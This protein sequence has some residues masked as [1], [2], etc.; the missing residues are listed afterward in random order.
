MNDSDEQTL[1][2]ARIGLVGL[3]GYSA[4]VLKLLREA[5]ASEDGLT[6]LTDVFVP[7][8]QNH[9]ATLAEL[10]DA[11]C[12]VHESFDALLA[13]EAEA[14]WLPVPIHLHRPMTEA[15]LAA[16]KTV[17]LEKPVAG[18]ID[19][20]DALMRAEA[21][22]EAA[23]L[24]GFQDVYRPISSSLKA[25]LLAGEFG[26]PTHATVLGL[27]PRP[28]S[29]YDRNNWAGA[30]RRDGTWVLDS[31]LNNAMAHYVNIALF[32]LGPAQETAAAISHV[33][34]DLL[35]ARHDIENF[36]TCSLRAGL[37]RGNNELSLVVNYSHAIDTNIQPHITIDTDRGVLEFAFNGAATFTPN[38]GDMTNLNPDEN[39]NPRP[40]MA[41]ALARAVRGQPQTG[42]TATLANARAHTLLVSAV[43]QAAEIVDIPAEQVTAHQQDDRVFLRVTRLAEYLREA[44]GARK[45]LAELGT[46]LPSRPGSLD[47]LENYTHF[48]G[49]KNGRV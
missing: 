44:T 14:V 10:G 9:E 26:T 7:D 25:R 35:R 13:S 15:T 49:P 38:Q 41:K 42:A 46:D 17:M 37:K 19:D 22:S 21:A 2:K 5:E 48:A 36:D 24:I 4:E 29:Y 40:P 12:V 1:D 3:G 16:G 39:R 32:L 45:T 30:M 31:P 18:C 28:Q 34:A 11:G 8:P 27:W 6:R 20:H 33:T 43:S 23:V 47:G